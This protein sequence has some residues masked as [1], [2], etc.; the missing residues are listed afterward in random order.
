MKGSKSLIIILVCVT[1]IGLGAFILF[2]KVLMKGNEPTN[3]I[4]DKNNDQETL[5]NIKIDTSKDYVYDATYTKN[6]N[7]NSYTTD[8]GTYNSDDL[9]VPYININSDDAKEANE[10][11][12]QT[13]EIMVEMYNTGVTD[14]QTYVENNYDY[15]LGKD[16]VSLMFSFGIGGSDVLVPSYFTYNFDLTDGDFL[17]LDDLT[18]KFNIKDFKTQVEEAIKHS[19]EEDLQDLDDSNYPEGTNFNSY[20]EET[21][22]DFEQNLENEAVKFFVDKDG[23]LNIIVRLSMPIGRGNS[24]KVITVG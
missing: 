5:N 23:K 7:A 18:E 17:D 2:D 8:F 24:T 12:K 16:F 20:Y 10:E 6:V 9:V 19:L 14:K 11:L 3:K 1:G 4:E 21:I 15:Y 22:D 13:F